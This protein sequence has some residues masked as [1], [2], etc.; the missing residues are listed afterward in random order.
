MTNKAQGPSAPDRM[1]ARQSDEDLEKMLIQPFDVPK[2]KEKTSDLESNSVQ[3]LIHE[4]NGLADLWK[5]TDARFE[6]SI[7]IYLAVSALFISLIM[8]LSQNSL[9]GGLFPEI[10]AFASM[11][12]GGIGVIFTIRLIDNYRRKTTYKQKRNKIRRFFADKA[13][14]LYF[15]HSSSDENEQDTKDVKTLRMIVAVI[16]LWSAVLVG[17]ALYTIMWRMIPS[18][19]VVTTLLMSSS[20]AM[21]LFVYLTI[22][23]QRHTKNLIVSDPGK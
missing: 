7:N 9:S 14:T 18:S 1:Q 15:L 21:I 13:P 2:M 4:Y 19:P 17:V 10:F 20:I 22:R 12:L 5:Y 16:H 11:S 3:F 8:F 23:T 6:S